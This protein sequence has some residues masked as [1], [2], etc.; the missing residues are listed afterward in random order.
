M[1]QFVHSGCGYQGEDVL[2]GRCPACVYA[3]QADALAALRE[4]VDVGWKVDTTDH[5][6]LSNSGSATI[7]RFVDDVYKSGK[8]GYFTRLSK[9]VKSQG[10]KF[11]TG[12]AMWPVVGDDFE[13]DGD[14]IKWFKPYSSRT[15]G[16]AIMRTSVYSAPNRY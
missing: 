10:R 9:S 15:G 4:R 12:Y 5:D 2:K 16:R 3:I 13:V 14:T 6:I 7:E 8:A 11:T 1:G